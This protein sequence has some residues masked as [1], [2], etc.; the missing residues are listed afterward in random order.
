MARPLRLDGLVVR[1]RRN[2]DRDCRVWEE[3]V[4]SSDSQPLLLLLLVGAGPPGEE[5]WLLLS[6]ASWRMLKGPLTTWILFSTP[7]SCSGAMECPAWIWCLQ[8]G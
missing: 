7:A 5:N 8:P 1:H 3:R 2:G 6:W 4:G